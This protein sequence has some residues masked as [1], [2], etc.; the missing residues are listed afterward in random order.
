LPGLTRLNLAQ[1]MFKESQVMRRGKAR[2]T[3]DGQAALRL[4]KRMKISPEP[5]NPLRSWR[6]L[7]NADSIASQSA[8]RTQMSGQSRDWKQPKQ[9]AFHW[10]NQLINRDTTR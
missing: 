4:T 9:P 10:L 5:L 7:W 6:E 3:S 2:Q 1:K 8:L